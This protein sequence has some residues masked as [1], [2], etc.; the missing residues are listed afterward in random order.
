MEQLRGTRTEQNLRTAFAG[1]SQAR[2]T[3]TYYAQKAEEGYFG[4]KKIKYDCIQNN[5]KYQTGDKCAGSFM[6]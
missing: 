5:E 1:E 4:C 3:Y 2:N 6:M